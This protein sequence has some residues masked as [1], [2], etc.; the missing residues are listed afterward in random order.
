MDSAWITDTGTYS[1]FDSQ[2][3][4][5][6]NFNGH[7]FC[8][9][10][11]AGSDNSAWPI[12]PAVLNDPHISRGSTQEVY[13]SMELAIPSS[14]L[15]YATDNAYI[16]F[17]PGL[18]V[19]KHLLAKAL[20]EGEMTQASS[21]MRSTSN[22]SINNDI[23]EPSPTLGVGPYEKQEHRPQQLRKRRQLKRRRIKPQSEMHALQ[24]NR[25][26]LAATAYR[27]RKKEEMEKMQHDFEKGKKTNRMLRSLLQR[28]KNEALDLQKEVLKH[29]NCVCRKID[30]PIWVRISESYSD[31]VKDSDGSGESS[32]SPESTPSTNSSWGSNSASSPLPNV[33]ETL[34]GFEH[35]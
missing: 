35:W 25:N 15:G 1:L 5:E 13:S 12:F 16:S 29:C 9:A 31:T 24:L 20:L 4:D 7:I 2:I 26:R 21:E 33:E 27:Y 23:I 19:S 17:E 10:P 18:N 30:C 11:Q 34:A 3:H 8:T 32:G 22:M 6:F 14:E 28:L